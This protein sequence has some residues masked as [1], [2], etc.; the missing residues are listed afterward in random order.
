MI[1]AGSISRIMKSG[2]KAVSVPASTP[3]DIVLAQDTYQAEKWVAYIT[4]L[5]QWVDD[6][7]GRNCVAPPSIPPSF[8]TLACSKRS[9]T[10]FGKE[11][12]WSMSIKL[13][14]NRRKKLWCNTAWEDNYRWS[15]RLV[16]Q[17]LQEKILSLWIT[18]K[19]NMF[20][21]IYLSWL[22]HFCIIHSWI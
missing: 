6:P 4:H 15:Y 2:R 16:Q 1:H 8:P 11:V 17:K 18:N 12:G 3:R 13:W 22:E 14:W 10:T 9:F 21:E 7:W 5:A 20:G 19:W